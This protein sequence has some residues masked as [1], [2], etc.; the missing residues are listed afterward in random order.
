MAL[1]PSTSTRAAAAGRRQQPP[2][3]RQYSRCY[4]VVLNC[5]VSIA[6]D[7]QQKEDYYVPESRCDVDIDLNHPALDVSP[8]IAI[9]SAGVLARAQLGDRNEDVNLEDMISRV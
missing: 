5:R 2:S 8:F 7:V 4:G 6:A 1:N 9:V 3:Q